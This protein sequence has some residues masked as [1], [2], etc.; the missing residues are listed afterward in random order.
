MNTTLPIVALLAL[1]ATV[2][3]GPIDPPSGPVSSTYRTLDQVEARTPID[4]E[5]T[6][7]DNDAT[8]SLFKITQPGSYYLTADV[9][10]VADKHGIEIAAGGVTIDLCGFRVAGV[11]GSRSGIAATTNTTGV[12]LINGHVSGWGQRG[13]DVAT[14][15]GASL[16]RVTASGNGNEGFALHSANLSKCSATGNTGQGFQYVQDC[17]FNACN[18]SLNTEGGFSG[19]AGRS[20]FDGCVASSNGT[21]GIDGWLNSTITACTAGGNTGVGIRSSVG[22]VTA[23]TASF[24]TGGGFSGSGMFKDNHAY[25]N[26]LDGF[27]LNAS[28]HVEGNCAMG[29]GE[30]STGSGIRVIA[31]RVHIKGNMCTQNDHGIRCEQIANIIVGNTCFA[32]PVTNF[33]ILAG[34]TTGPYITSTGQIA[35]T[36]PFANFS[37]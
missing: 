19:T 16:D 17:I 37:Y 2:N 9:A 18:A 21:H 34:N 20:V 12:R 30:N 15:L 4:A 23:C 27:F 33:D 28:G 14:C 10:G 6:P 1:A 35:S 25:R 36:N 13:V 11:A 31:Q 26:G 8:P 24:N 32:N 29:N 22:T 3:A 7:G 5:H